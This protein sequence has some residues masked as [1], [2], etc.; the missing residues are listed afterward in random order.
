MGELDHGEVEHQLM[1]AIRDSVCRSR[2]VVAVYLA[3]MPPSAALPP[4]YLVGVHVRGDW[5]DIV[6]P[7][8]R[9]A[10][11]Q[12]GRGINVDYWYFVSSSKDELSLHYRTALQPFYRRRTFF[13][14]F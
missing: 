9:I 11:T 5:R 7:L 8:A 2:H 4:G 6:E 3:M 12:A 10:H 13:G 1:A 14:L